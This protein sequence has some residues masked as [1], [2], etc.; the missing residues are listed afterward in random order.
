MH[1]V[2]DLET[3]G[4][5]PGSVVFSIGCVALNE[6]YSPKATFY[7]L[8]NIMD[9]M[10]NGLQADPETLKWW[11]K[12][13]P[14]AISQ[15]KDAYVSP[16]KLKDV[17]VDFNSWVR[18]HEGDKSKVLLWGYGSDFDNALLAACYKK[19][20]QDPPWKYR[21]SRCLRTLSSLVSV[22]VERE[23]TY[24]NALDD[25]VYQSKIL[26]RILSRMGG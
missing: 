23:G 7:S 25:A 13:T 20:K 4:T 11:T 12:Q 26:S 1:F 21:G 5:V 9:S 18:S 15:L 2:L 22:Q 10:S 24:H 17:L 19:M 3:L 8:I 16:R 6:D 14:E